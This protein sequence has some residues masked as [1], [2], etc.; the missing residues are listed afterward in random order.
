MAADIN[1]LAPSDLP[2]AQRATVLMITGLLRDA[3][4]SPIYTPVLEAGAAALN[5]AIEIGVDLDNEIAKLRRH[6]RGTAGL[7]V[8]A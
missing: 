4:L 6:L 1:P 8:G 5:E 2:A 7:A 3:A